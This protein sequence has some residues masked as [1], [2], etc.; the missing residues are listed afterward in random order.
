[1]QEELV[2]Y[3]TAY[4]AKEKGFVFWQPWAYY[5]QPDDGLDMIAVLE[6]TTNHDVLCYA[7]TQA[8]LQRWLREIHKIDVIATP[9]TTGKDE[10]MYIW[11]IYRKVSSTKFSKFFNRYEKALEDGLF[12]ALNLIS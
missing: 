12:E 1:M 8:L 6:K 9:Y 11:M 7:P 2:T 4:L 3:K 5:S 10:F